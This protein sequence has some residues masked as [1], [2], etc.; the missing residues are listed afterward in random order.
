MCQWNV[1]R[2]RLR[3]LLAHLPVSSKKAVSAKAA[4]PAAGKAPVPETLLKKRKAAAVN[5]AERAAALAEKRKVRWRAR[6]EARVCAKGNR[7]TSWA[8]ASCKHGVN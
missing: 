3:L 8:V 5:S 2:A 6:S 4:A 1:N 7:R